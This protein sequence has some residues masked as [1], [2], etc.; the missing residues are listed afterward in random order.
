MTI[1]SITLSTLTQRIASVNVT[2]LLPITCLATLHLSLFGWL[3]SLRPLVVGAM[4]AYFPNLAAHIISI[5]S[6]A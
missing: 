4:V 5:T 1:G 2:F 3:Y 6:A